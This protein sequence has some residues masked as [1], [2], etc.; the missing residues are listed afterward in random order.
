MLLVPW[1]QSDLQREIQGVRRVVALV[2]NADELGL[3]AERAD[4]LGGAGRAGAE[5]RGSPLRTDRE[6]AGGG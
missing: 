4:D 3:R 2:R 6:H 5:G 1:A